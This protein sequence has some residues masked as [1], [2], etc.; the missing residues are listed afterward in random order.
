MSDVKAGVFHHVKPLLPIH[1]LWIGSRIAADPQDGWFFFCDF[2][3]SL[4][5]RNVSFAVD[6]NVEILH[7]VTSAWFVSRKLRHLS[8][9]QNSQTIVVALDIGWN[10]IYF[11]SQGN[12]SLL[13]L[14]SLQPLTLWEVASLERS[15]GLCWHHINTSPRIWYVTGSYRF[16]PPVLCIF[17]STV[18]ETS[19]SSDLKISNF[20][21][22]EECAFNFQFKY[23]RNFELK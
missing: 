20:F 3:S 22:N 14:S 21:L 2:A 15:Q 23:M 12:Q 7:T 6:H 11:K 9:K 10:L 16:F 18:W 5:Y 13:R 17:S 19:I 8:G 1:W 4:N